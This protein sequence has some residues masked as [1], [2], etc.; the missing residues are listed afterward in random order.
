[1]S[2]N[3]IVHLNLFVLSSGSRSCTDPGLP[4]HS[5]SPA[6]CGHQRRICNCH[7][8]QGTVKIMTQLFRHWSPP[9][10]FNQLT[11][12]LLYHRSMTKTLVRKSEQL[13]SQ[14]IGLTSCTLSASASASALYTLLSQNSTPASFSLKQFK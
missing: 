2:I 14:E 13:R 7:P 12:P 10:S 9:W 1:M 4:L 11:T 3:F 6:N 5:D 8:I